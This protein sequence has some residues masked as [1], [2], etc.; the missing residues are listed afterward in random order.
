MK[1]LARIVVAAAAACSA[2]CVPQEKYDQLN[3]SHRTVVAEK[4]QVEQDLFDARSVTDNLRTKATAL[5]GELDTKSQLVANLQG[6]NDRLDTAFASCQK[7]LEEIAGRPLP[8]Q[9]VIE[10]TIL[11]EVLDS[12]LKRFAAQYP[13]AVAYDAERGAVKWKSDLLFALGSAVVKDSAKG[14]LGGF[15]EIIS[16]ADA[17]EFDVI[18]VGHTDDRQPSRETTKRD[19]PTNWHLSV[20]RAIAVSDVL[21]TDG[22][23]ETRVGVMGYGEY[24]PVLSNDTEENRAKNRRVEIFILPAGTIAATAQMGG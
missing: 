11:P 9:A 13:S 20:H 19:H 21:Q 6:E 23:P 12:A 24:R 10:R 1:T 4:T 16:S 5:E 15:A 3:M 8:N 17:A 2:G 7:T 14:S 18:I 22:V